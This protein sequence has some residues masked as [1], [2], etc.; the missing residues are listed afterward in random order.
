M[1][2]DTRTAM[3]QLIAEARTQMPLT[4]PGMTECPDS[5]TGCSVKLL[6]YLAM[7]LEGWEERLDA[8]EKPRLGDISQLARTCRKIY[9]V[10]QK[11]G[12]TG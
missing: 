2:P 6:E 9:R 10:L 7:E 8:G 4:Q 1:K 5:C 3:R 12:V 11:N